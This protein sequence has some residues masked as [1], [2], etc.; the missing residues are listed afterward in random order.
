MEFPEAD[1]QLC[2]PASSAGFEVSGH[3][4]HLWS[5]Q[6]IRPDLDYN[7][8]LESLSEDER[9]RA[10]GYHFDRDRRE[11]ITRRHFVRIILSRY[12]KMEP[13][14][15]ELVCEERGKPRLAGAPETLPLHFNLSHSRHLALL[16]ICRACP[17]GV[18][19]EK[20]RPMPEMDEIAANFFSAQERAQFAAANGTQEKLEAFFTVWTRKEAFLKATGEGIAMQLGQ[21]DCSQPRP[22]WSMVPLAPAPGFLGAVALGIGHAAPICRQWVE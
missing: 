7:S 17:V 22:D 14:Q 9:L 12:L 18:D 21:I 16:A 11:F 15:I 2:W 6:L 20:I 19:V 1:V 8:R 5:S 10:R 3:E 13:A 4:V